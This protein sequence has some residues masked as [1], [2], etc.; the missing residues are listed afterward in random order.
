MQAAE[1]AQKIRD[2]R[3]EKADL[4]GNANDMERAQDFLK[5][6]NVKVPSRIAPHQPDLS[7]I[8]CTTLEQPCK[9]VSCLSVHTSMPSML[10]VI[11]RL[12]ITAL[13]LRT[14]CSDERHGTMSCD[15]GD[16]PAA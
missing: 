6:G 14:S 11:L 12:W 5:A 8:S 3:K 15:C 4:E 1:Q 7:A 16:Q 13:L 9:A 10:Q 2:A